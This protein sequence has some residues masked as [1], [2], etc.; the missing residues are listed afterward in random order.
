METSTLRALGD[1]PVIH[2]SNGTVV[3]AIRPID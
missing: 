1:P 3:E 2:L